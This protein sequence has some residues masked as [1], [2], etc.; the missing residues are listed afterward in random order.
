MESGSLIP[1]DR[2]DREHLREFERQTSGI[3]I[4]HTH[5]L[6]HDYAQRRYEELTG[7]KPPVPG[8]RSRRTMRREERRKDDKI[9][10]KISEESGHSR[11]S[12]TSIY[13]GN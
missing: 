7:R 12:V 6:R 5:S 10:Q 1:P 4:G 3:G 2:R 9:R 13:P 11:I 8:G